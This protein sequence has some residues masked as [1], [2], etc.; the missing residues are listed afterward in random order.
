MKI[1]LLQLIG[2]CILSITVRAQGGFTIKQYQVEVNINQ[3][4]SLDITEI[5][6][7]RF[8]ENRHGI[9]RSIPYKYKLATLPPGEE[10]ANRQLESKG[11]TKTIIEDIRVAGWDYSVSNEGDYKVI[12]IGDKNRYVNGDQEYVIQ[13]RLLNAINFFTDKSEFYFN[14]IGNQ[15]ETTIDSVSFIITLYDSL[16]IPAPFFVATGIT[17]SQE[18]Q[19]VS[20]W[21]NNKVF[22]GHTIVQLQPNEGV[23]VGLSFPEGFLIRTNYMNRGILWLLLP[24]IIFSLML[25]IWN[26]W[27]KDEKLTITTEFYPPENISPSVAGYIIDDRL[28]KRD[29]TALIPYWGAGGYLQ[30]R[31]ISKKTLFGL[32]KNTEYEFIRLK[33][34]PSSAMTFERILFNGIFTT[35]STVELSSLKN[36]LYTTMHTAKQELE[37]EVD[38]SAYYVKYSR[39]L[40]YFFVILGIFTIGYGISHLIRHWGDPY[41]YPLS[42][43]ISGLVIMF[44]GPPMTRK[45][46]RGND[47]YKKLAGFKAFIKSVEK[48][49]L[50]TFLKEDEHYFDKVLPFAIV[51]DMADKWKDKLKGLDVTPPSWYAGNFNTFNTSVFLNSLDRSMNEMSRTFYSSPS[52]S[53]SSGGSWSSG[54]SSGGGFGGGGGGSW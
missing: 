26:R 53:G 1:F 45:S 18:N 15:W 38:R 49:R 19:T 48:D 28:D 41:W 23:T 22:A 31:E 36:V 24:G 42:V 2:L 43:I 47:L 54:G 25:Y 5:I 10:K 3:D 14:V 39:G 37:R 17:G 44:F 52:S 51:F 16:Q 20:S 27:G 11:Y 12:K 7:I 46:G 32:I 34:L 35:G 21:I 30:I 13:Y 33:E 9:F 50:A 4:A 6:Q 40:V 8:D 29:L